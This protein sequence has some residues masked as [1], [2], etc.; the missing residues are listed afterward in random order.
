MAVSADVVVIGAGIAGVSVAAE[1]AAAARVVV[2][3]REAQPGYHT[4]GRSAAFFVPSYGNATVRAITAASE[5]FYRSPGEDFAGAPLLRP[6]HC[7]YF[8]RP[9][10]RQALLALHE[11]QPFLQALSVPAL[12]QRVPIMRPDR[13]QG[14]L[15]DDT[16]GDLDVA[17]ILQGFLRRLRRRGGQLRAAT[18]A[19]GLAHSKGLWR[20]DTGGE[21][22]TAPIVVNAAGSW[23]N[24]V[25][26]LTGLSPLAL[27][28]LRRTALLVDAPPGREVSDWPLMI[29]AEEEFYFKPY[30]GAILIS[31]ADE[32]PSDPC[33]AQPEELDVALAV[34]RYEQATGLEVARVTHRWAGLR[35]FAPDRTFVAGFDP[36]AQGFFWLAGQGGYG[37]Q[38]A[39]GLSRLAAALVKGESP[40][41][42]GMAAAAVTQTLSPARLLT[43][44]PGNTRQPPARA[45]PAS[46]CSCRA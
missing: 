36:R 13:L 21:T 1:L 12:C 44:Q 20:V 5:A 9:E 38:T 18:M 42:P 30:A 25:A 29:N 33:D 14:G 2:L 37:V 31:P 45:E 8:G 4:T 32:T 43:P 6:R 41:I 40:A 16:G 26:G 15:L 46:A 35:T 10:Q 7:I 17:A 22:L 28:P 34:D 39:P 24:Q 3:E 19:R 23:A 11:A 27:Q